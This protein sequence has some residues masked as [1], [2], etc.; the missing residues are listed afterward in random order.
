MTIPILL[1]VL[2]FFLDF[3]AFS[4]LDIRIQIIGK[5]IFVKLFLNGISS[6][7]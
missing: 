7:K 5:F 4:L 1:S 2:F 3:N 6:N